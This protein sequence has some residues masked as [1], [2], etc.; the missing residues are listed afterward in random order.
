MIKILVVDD[1]QKKLSNIRNLIESIPELDEIDTATNVVNAKRLMSFISYD[2]LILD[3]CLP[4]RDGEDAL[5]ENGINLLED[6]NKTQRIIKPYHIIGLSEFDDYINQF[7]TSFEDDLWALVK[8]DV[9]SITWETKIKKKIEYLI[10]S[11]RSLQNPK[12]ISY[13]YDIAIIT[14]LRSI[15][16]ESVL[17]LPANWESM[18][19]DN[20]ATEYFKGFFTSSKK[21]LKVVAASAPQMGMVASSVLAN[22]IINNF[23][24]KHLVMAGIAAGVKGVGNFGDILSAEISYD[25]GSGKIKSD[26]NGDTMFEPDYRSIDSNVDVKESI[27]ACKTSRIYLDDIKKNWVGNKPTTE[28]NIHFGP[29]ASGAGVIQNKKIIEE[30]KGHSRKLIG[31]DMETYGVFYTAKNCS[32]PRPHSVSSFKSV[33]DF[34]DEEK[35][36]DYQKYAGYTSAS[37]IYNFALNNMDFE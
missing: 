1:N 25:S 9:T 5:P 35:N 18:K 29:F 30:I 20:D 32:K 11:K 31:F 12:Q 2:L 8:Y 10:E 4:M 6:I 21:K 27:L 22:K 23:R 19:L 7:K 36:D 26:E 14:A 16:L 37:Y 3:L 13:Q 15:E 17:N 34:G 24:P 28:L 33:C